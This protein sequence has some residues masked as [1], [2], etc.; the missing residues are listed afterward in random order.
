MQDALTAHDQA[1]ATEA[2]SLSA[3][4]PASKKRRLVGKLAGPGTKPRSRAASAK[5]PPATR[6][7]FAL[8]HQDGSR[9]FIEVKS[10]T[11]C[12]QS[13]HCIVTCISCF[14]ADSRQ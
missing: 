4:E 11:L 10:V 13:A 9:T 6:C 14:I 5:A 8:K 2:D 3:P 12:E 1:N 7:D